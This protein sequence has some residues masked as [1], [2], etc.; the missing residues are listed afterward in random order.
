M[1][2][3]VFT[4]EEMDAAFALQ[5]AGV[6]HPK[7]PDAAWAKIEARWSTLRMEWG[8]GPWIDRCP[9]Q[10][11]VRTSGGPHVNLY[12]VTTE[13]WGLEL[14]GTTLPFRH[15]GTLDELIEKVVAAWPPPPPADQKNEAQRSY[16]AHVAKQRE[17]VAKREEQE[18]RRDEASHEGVREGRD[19]I[20]S[21]SV[22]LVSLPPLDRFKGG[23]C[24]LSWQG[25]EDGK[26]LTA[27]QKRAARALVDR[28]QEVL[29]ALLD[30]LFQDQRRSA[31]DEDFPRAKGPPGVLRLVALHGIV[32]SRDER[33]GVA[34]TD[35]AFSDAWR[36]EH[37]LHACMLGARLVGV[38]GY[39]DV[40][41]DPPDD[42][43][44]PSREPDGARTPD[45]WLS[46]PHDAVVALPMWEGFPGRWKVSFVYEDDEEIELTAGQVDAVHRLVDDGDAIRDA[47]LAALF[48]S[49]EKST[50]AP[51]PIREPG[52]LKA[53]LEPILLRVHA[54][55]VDRLAYTEFS[56]EAP[57]RKSRKATVVMHGARVVALTTG[58]GVEDAIMDDQDASLR[59]ARTA[60]AAKKP[61]LGKRRSSRARRSHG[62]RSAPSGPPHRR[63]SGRAASRRPRS[64]GASSWFR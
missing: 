56:V 6:P 43:D 20:A 35:F 7:I 44:D 54:E 34:F 32:I 37:G 21:P 27:A 23:A 48:S 59:A 31:E 50:P 17:L 12:R 53:I 25:V 9:H 46:D 64:P 13:V 28:G 41:H 57:W 11:R 22:G 38:G 18:R 58:A 4:K 63:G 1:L 8:R 3:G 16:E 33:G 26:P 36:V 5:D 24:S 14:D 60:K 30:G 15:R 55:D 10:V 61:K 39:G 40:G 49:Y 52:G 47:L 2:P 29:D 19:W 42:D 51:R 45:K 62:R